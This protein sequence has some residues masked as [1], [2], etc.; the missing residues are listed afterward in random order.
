MVAFH[1]PPL[2]G[3]SGIMRTLSFCRHLGSLGWQPI[4][5]SANPRA[6]RLTGDDLLADIPADTIVNRAF[7]LDSRKHLSIAGRYSLLTALPDAWST[8]YLGAIPNGLSII[9]KY[10]PAAIWSTYPIAT[11]HAISHTLARLTKLPWI[12]DLRDPMVEPNHPPNPLERK[13]RHWVERRALRNAALTTYTAPGTR[14]MYL[15]RYPTIARDRFRLIENGYDRK[16]LESVNPEPSAGG[17]L[18]LLHSGIVYPSERDPTAFF[19]AICKLRDA[20]TVTPDRLRVVFRASSYDELYRP[21]VVKR[22][23]TEIV[24]FEPAISYQKALK[25]M[26]EADGLL[27]IQADN[28]NSQIPAKVYEYFAAQRPILALT[29]PAGDTAATVHRAGIKAVFRW[30]DSAEIAAGL[31]RFVVEKEFR[32]SLIASPESVEASARDN[33]TKELAELLDEVVA[34]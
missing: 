21:M 13:V 11:A 9:R 26:C 25:E 3:S 32:S 23:I 7:A 1:F 29:D 22:N 30:N 2:R 24:K 5:L 8:W 4:V 20:G 33:R 19:D 27:V 18:T 15:D 12:A 14:Q 31:A 17:P 28:C 34:R 10:R 6:Y 16:M